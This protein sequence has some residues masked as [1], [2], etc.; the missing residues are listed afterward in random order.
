MSRVSRFPWY[1]IFISIYPALFYW[2][3][4]A[5]E[6][7]SI[8]GSKLVLLSF[9]FGLL[10]W[11][12]F[13]VIYRNL[14]KASLATFV[15]LLLFWSYGHLHNY[16]ITIHSLVFRHAIHLTGW[17]ILFLILVVWLFR[18][19]P[20][21]PKVGSILNLVTAFLLVYPLIQVVPRAVEENQRLK[22]RAI[23]PILAPTNGI[24]PVSLDSYPD[25]YYIILDSYTRND[26]LNSYFSFDN[27]EF[28]A[29]LEELGFY[30][31]DCSQS[32]YAQTRLSLASSL[33]Y[34]FLDELFLIDPASKNVPNMIKRSA[35]QRI[36]E[37]W[38]YKIVAFE[39][40][41]TN[42]ELTDASVYYSRTMGFFEP[43]EFDLSFLE[44][45]FLQPFMEE[46]I[47]R[48]DLMM[49]AQYRAR[50]LFVL[51]KLDDSARIKGPKFVFAHV[52][53]PHPPFVLG[54]NG[55]EI[56]MDENT[57]DKQADRKTYI[58]G[59]VYQTQYTNK[60]IIEILKRII[61]ESESAPIIIVQGDHG[62]HVGKRQVTS[63]LNAYY[64]PGG[65][66]G[67]YENITPVNTFR[68]LFNRYFGQNLEMEDDIAYWSAVSLP[69]EFEVIDN[70]CTTDFLTSS[71]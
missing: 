31:A 10:C 3:F 71:P 63:I 68:Y 20:E 57:G 65:Y 28:L 8:N 49:T 13:L 37:E 51:D 29:Q 18:K 41:H 33:N 62:P 12:V 11:A 40:G 4:N 66:E 61:A 7:S 39:T 1:V 5:K 48:S 42:S 15:A 53:I 2:A 16:L 70:Q 38:G 23:E 45:S 21:I 67:L 46:S 22:Q 34:R 32:N 44:T 56:L 52:L 14:G 27:S 47:I 35:V 9:F 26:V 36:F 25:V 17:A 55:E 30:V 60:R 59:F 54:P 6:M 69:L 50:I 58:T 19:D 64:L 43:T 24:Q